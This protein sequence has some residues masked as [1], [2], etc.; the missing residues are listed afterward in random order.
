[1]WVPDQAHSMEREWAARNLGLDKTCGLILPSAGGGVFVGKL[2]MAV[3]PRIA[4]AAWLLD[5]PVRCEYTR[6]E[7]MAATT[8]RHASRVT[9]RAGCDRD[10]KLTALVFDGAFDTGA[11]A[12]WG[13]TV[14]DRVPVHCSGPY[15]VPDVLA[16]SGRSEEHKSGLQSL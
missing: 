12:S 13:P 16:R 4:L 2:D 5:R 6:P 10:G 8:K 3:Q 9:A 11:Y 14:A 1:M 15:R 7:S